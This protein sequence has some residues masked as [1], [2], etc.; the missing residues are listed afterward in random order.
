M[1]KLYQIH[2]IKMIFN[3]FQEDSKQYNISTIIY[4]YKKEFKLNSKKFYELYESTWIFI[5]FRR[6]KDKPIKQKSF[7]NNG[8][9]DI[10]EAI[11]FKYL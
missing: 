8:I 2:Q 3:N 1:K 11:K 7:Y 9:E 4:Y 6:E 10:R 5:N